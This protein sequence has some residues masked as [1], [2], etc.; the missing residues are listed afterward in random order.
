[1]GSASSDTRVDEVAPDIFRICTFVPEF[2]LQF[3]QF[4]IRDE[5][6][7]L[8][9]TGLRSLFP[10]VREAV[11]RL[12]DLPSLRWISFSHFEADECGS[13]NEWLELAP[14]CE[15]AC[16][17]V[18]ALVSVDDFSLR[19]ARQLAE[20][21]RLEIGRHVLRFCSTPQVPHGWDA[22]LLY[23]ETTESLF[24]SDLLHQLG[25]LEAT[26]SESNLVERFQAAL[27]EYGAGPF[28]NYLPWTPKTRSTLDGLAALEP[29]HVLPMHG[30]T[31]D[32]DG[33]LLLREMAEMMQSEL[34]EG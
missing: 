22:G 27:R 2:Q 23:D 32:G 9:H 18:G 34:A 12:I 15:P 24:C 11:G 13:L 31:Y 28:A 5:E 10:A 8:I 3:S 6:P 21:D 1:M 30:T 25:D 20:G 14:R 33:G 26:T 16:S 7:T 17:L 19:P 29:R 4:L